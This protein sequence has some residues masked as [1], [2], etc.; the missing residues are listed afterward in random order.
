MER[1]YQKEYALAM[2][3]VAELQELV[4]AYQSM[5]DDAIS[6]DTE[7]STQ[8]EQTIKANPQRLYG[9]IESNAL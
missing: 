2:K 4:F 9:R 7:D 3:K 5:L 8:A 1:N 6:K